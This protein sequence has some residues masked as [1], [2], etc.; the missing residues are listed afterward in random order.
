MEKQSVRTAALLDYAR[1]D[2]WDVVVVVVVY[3][4]FFYPKSAQSK[5]T[6][7]WPHI[8]HL[9]KRRCCIH[10]IIVPPTSAC[11]NHSVLLSSFT[12]SLTACF[13]HQHVPFRPSLIDC[14]KL[15]RIL[16]PRT[17]HDE[18]CCWSRRPPQTSTNP[19]YCYI[20][21]W[22]LL[23]GVC[24]VQSHLLIRLVAVEWTAIPH[25]PVCL[26]SVLV[27]HQAQKK[28]FLDVIVCPPKPNSRQPAW[29]RRNLAAEQPHRLL[30]SKPTLPPALTTHQRTGL[31]H[32]ARPS[33]AS[34]RG[35]IPRLPGSTPQRRGAPGWLQLHHRGCLQAMQGKPST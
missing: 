7:F 30:R 2:D 25:P 13:A 19:N 31:M 26:S 8:V 1:L 23:V 21:C 32:A 16:A 12:P 28:G 4:R 15:G 14:T 24:E 9:K 27:H 5:Y 17:C 22:S 10:Q 29:L 18:M 11:C 33:C 35:P 34:D 6:F 3:H 20:S